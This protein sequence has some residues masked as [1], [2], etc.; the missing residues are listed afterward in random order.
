MQ[1]RSGDS[2]FPWNIPHCVFMSS[3]SISVFSVC[4]R[5]RV[6]QQLMTFL[7]NDITL[8]LIPINSMD[9]ITQQC[10]TLPKAF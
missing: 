8:L 3:L 5:I 2:E 1:N 6:L 9:L 4:R 7:V 10:G